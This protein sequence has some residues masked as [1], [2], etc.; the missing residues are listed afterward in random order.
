M[1]C[2]RRDEALLPPDV[3]AAAIETR[4]YIKKFRPGHSVWLGPGTERVWHFDERTPPMGWQ[5]RADAFM[6]II[7]EAGH[8]I[9]TGAAA[10]RK[11]KLIDDN[12]NEHFRADC[13]NEEML[14]EFIL[15]SNVIA[16][17]L[18]LLEYLP[19]IPAMA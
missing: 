9:F 5:V 19:T 12:T 18:A 10:L 17:F 3:K 13:G 6:E 2:P 4:D 8:P 7:K 11:G 14:V 15:D 1:L 16:S